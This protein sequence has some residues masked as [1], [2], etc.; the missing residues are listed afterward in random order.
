MP[1]GRFDW[2]RSHRRGDCA[3]GVDEMTSA[4]RVPAKDVGNLNT[5]GNLA[6]EVY[7]IARRG[8][9]GPLVEPSRS[10]LEE[11]RRIFENLM[12]YKRPDG[13]PATRIRRMASMEAA[14]SILEEG[15]APPNAREGLQGVLAA[16][17]RILESGATTTDFDLVADYFNALSVAS[18]DAADGLLRPVSPRSRWSTAA[19]G[20]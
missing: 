18:V 6:D 15:E 20:F 17:T 7:L 12:N 8:H 9:L 4:P 14:A 19:S 16:I 3:Y 11:V 10:V 5:L 1:D 2:L 13:P